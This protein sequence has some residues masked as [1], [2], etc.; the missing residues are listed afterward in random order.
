MFLHTGFGFR[1]LGGLGFQG[2]RLLCNGER[3][4]PNEDV[5]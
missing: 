1:V 2:Q 3:S 4:D 5:A